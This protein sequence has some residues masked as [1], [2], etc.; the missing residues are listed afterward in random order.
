VS[1]RA[2]HAPFRLAAGGLI[3]RARR[4]NA[5][6]DG[7]PLSGFGGD[8]L[9]SAL[10][11]SGKRLVGRSFKYHRPRGIFSAGSEEP[12]ALVELRTGA[13]REPNTRATTVEL[14]EGLEASSQNRW[15]SLRFDLLSV[16]SLL[17]PIIGA[18]FYYKT[19][20][21]PAAFWE[22][23][24]EP[25]IRRAAGL[26]RAA[27][28]PD[29]DHYEH[30]YAFCDVLIIGAG[31]AGIMAAMT[32][33]RA[34]ARVIICDEDFCFGGRLL[35]DLREIDGQCGQ[36]WVAEKLEELASFPDIRLMS[37]TTVFGV[38]DGHTYGAVERV[39]DHLA[40]PLSHQPRQRL[41]RIVSKRAILAA[42][43][44]ER[45]IVFGGNDRP[46]IMLAAAVRTYINRFAVV[47]G[48]RVAL[49][50][51]NDDGWRTG[52]DLAKA[53]FEI[54]AIIDS[55]PSPPPASSG[56]LTAP[57]ISGGEIVATRGRTAVR[58]ITVR[59]PGG[60]QNIDV[61][62]VG[63]AGGW[64]PNINLTGHHGGRPVWNDQLVAFVPGVS[65]PGLIP[66][67]AANGTM[68]LANCLAAGAAA[69]RQV[70]ED[71]GFT[72][73]S[74]ALPKA[75]DEP[76]AISPMWHVVGSAGKAFVDFQNDVTVNDIA[77]A[78]R[79]G[80]RSVEHLKRY[81]TLGMATDQGKNSNVPGL[82]IMAALTGQSIPETG[83]TTY[84]PPYTPV[85]IGTLAGHHRGR[86]FRPTR[87]TPSY[88]WAESQGAVFVDAGLWLRA[89]YFPK[90]GERDW[91]ETVTREV[92]TVR[93]SVGFCD[94]STLG[95]ID[96]Q[97]PDAGA[98]L[99]RVYINTFSTLKVGRARYG[100]MLREDGLVFDDGTVSRLAKNY[101]FMTTTTANAV[102][103]FQHL[104]FCHQVLWPELDVQMA[105]TTDQWAQFSVAGPRAR[106]TIAAL[107]DAPFDLNTVAFPYMAVA[108]LTVCGSV[109][110]RLFRLSFSGEL[111]YEIAVPARY[112]HAMAQALMQAGESFG[113]APYGTEAL[114]VMRIEKGHVAGN[115]LDGRTTAADLGLGRMM[116]KNKDYVGRVMAERPGLLAPERQTLVGLSP[117][118][119]TDRLH[120]G[121]HL[122]LGQVPATAA[123]DAGVVT[124]VAFSPSLSRW[125]GL[126][127][128][129]NGGARLGERI[130]AVDPVRNCRV[131]VDVCSTCFIDPKGERL[132]G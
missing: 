81:T 128:L 65:P 85:T 18:G 44:T 54:A 88:A 103:V 59:S 7:V 86:E 37:R 122:I 13:R 3:D 30:A 94:V 105:S 57:V 95:K 68:S 101:F 52:A 53:G 121:A 93:S 90:A 91:L 117:A 73:S 69:G 66:I 32:A 111:A 43:A 45:G 25:L 70:A 16:T 58:S 31:P 29:P 49:F 50:V 8:T 99:D 82:A 100:V 19:F 112:G 123:N 28:L 98:F 120:A 39:A 9:A 72:V 116:S 42:G 4:I 21:W 75:D 10:L 108:E 40:E 119:E 106:D 76:V 22:R 61:D 89:Q 5:T 56:L 38:Y 62:A 126:G 64:N 96:V 97:G 12:N 60:T 34:G 113:I 125:I 36:L 15:P 23:V 104:Q 6:L 48:H 51:N 83:T 102:R 109:P 84:R 63:V 79:E 77:L 130:V 67:G 107:A 1:A 20:M 27:E 35:S 33:A 71:A 110:A 14:F 11:A 41:W 80:F 17:G 74:I 118:I 132:H 24:Y 87:L 2:E 124:S 114:G 47:P 131:G 55:R 92:N 115:E 46:G 78:H 127:L 26:G 129:A